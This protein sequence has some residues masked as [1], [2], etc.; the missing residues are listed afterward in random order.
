MRHAFKEVGD[1]VRS[2]AA[3]RFSQYDARTAA[4]FKVKV[5]QRGISVE[6]TIGKTTGL[7]PDFGRLQMRR[8]LVP[9]LKDKEQETEAAFEAAMLHVKQVFE[10]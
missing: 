7:R 10:R 5:R 1:I 3:Q 2:D 4:G 6:Q 8:G 9:A